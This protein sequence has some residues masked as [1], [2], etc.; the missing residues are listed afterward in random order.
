[1]ASV[2]RWGCGKKGKDAKE[3]MGW[4]MRGPM[5][6]PG[7]GRWGLSRGWCWRR[8]RTEQVRNTFRRKKTNRAFRCTGYG[9]REGPHTQHQTAGPTAVVLSPWS[10]E[11]GSRWKA[12]GAQDTEWG[13]EE[14]QRLY[15]PGSGDEDRSKA[16]KLRVS[17][18][19]LQRE[20]APPPPSSLNARV[21]PSIFRAKLPAN[22]L[23]MRPLRTLGPVMCPGATS[24]GRARLGNEPGWE[25]SESRLLRGNQQKG[26]REEGAPL[27]CI[28][29]FTKPF[30]AR[31][32]TPCFWPWVLH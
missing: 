12:L 14:A 16:S 21:R 25:Q 29:L 24:R 2:W 26:R 8:Q 22:A 32:V 30:P 15:L 31:A 23:G 6:G 18:E 10:W 17:R 11:V 28:H 19:G 7:E 20:R 3:P 27:S 9:A 4:P 13:P 1:M 5:R